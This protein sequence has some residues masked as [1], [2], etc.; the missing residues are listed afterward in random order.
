MSTD[1]RRDYSRPVV[2]LPDYLYRDHAPRSSPLRAY[3]RRV[4]VADAGVVVVA[5]TVGYLVRFGLPTTAQ[6]AFAPYRA[7]GFGLVLL[8][9]GALYV[10]G[11]YDERFLGVGPEEF[12]RLVE[13][14]ILLFAVVAGVSYF[15]DSDVSRIYVFVSLP[16]GLVMLMVERWLAR[17]LL[18]RARESGHSCFRTVVIGGSERVADLTAEMQSDHYAGYVVVASHEPPEPAP[19]RLDAWVSSVSDLVAS[20]GA[21]AVAVTPSRRIGADAVRH[22]AWALE[23]RGI[24]LLVAPALSDVAGPRITMRPAAGVPLIH[25][26]EPGLT[27][28]QRV[29][30]RGLDIVGSIIALVVL[31][32][33][34]LIAALLVRVTSTGPAL[35]R[36]WRVGQHGRTFQILKFRTMDVDA[37][38]GRDALRRATGHDDPAFKAHDDPR[39]TRTGRFLRRWSID[40][41]PQLVNVLRND[42]SL[43]GPRPHPLDDVARYGRDD[44]RRL[45]AK[46]GI[47]GL[48]QVAGRSDLDWRES[49]QLDLHYVENWSMTRD[50]VLIARTVRAVVTG[51]GAR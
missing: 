18:Y 43:V 4:A 41:W 38:A 45:L 35:F 32:V 2:A 48:W 5:T 22:L 37:D 12:N 31:A 27:S 25:L 8:W 14:A 19:E 42:M 21:D 9:L 50:L 1:E 49:I 13:A 33:P 44:Y 11:C 47:T 34:M 6:E 24:D 51:R 46:P 39:I 7:L 23:G 36:Q 15:F 3:R 26:E 17:R 20:V 10:R 28:P 30:K 40:E 29:A 16:L